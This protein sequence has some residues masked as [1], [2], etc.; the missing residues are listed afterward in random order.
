VRDPADQTPS[1]RDQLTLAFLEPTLTISE[2]D[3]TAL[4]QNSSALLANVQG[5]IDHDEASN[6]ETLVTA[7]KIL[8]PSDK[9]LIAKHNETTVTSAEFTSHSEHLF[10]G[11]QMIA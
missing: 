11:S 7:A 1:Q 3:N 4:Y 10:S 9:Y 5:L 2:D 8:Q 6:T